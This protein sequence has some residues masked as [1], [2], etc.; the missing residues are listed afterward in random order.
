[1]EDMGPA[2]VVM[3][4]GEED[5]EREAE[6]E[7]MVLEVVAAGTVKAEVKLV[8]GKALAL[9]KLAWDMQLQDICARGIAQSHSHQQILIE[10]LRR[11]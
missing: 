7:G 2:A 1:M 3:D 6:E 5:K 8:V 9:D 11:M 4:T 10:R